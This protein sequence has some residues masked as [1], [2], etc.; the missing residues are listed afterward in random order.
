[1]GR[2]LWWEQTWKLHQ[3][4]KTQAR[5]ITHRGVRRW[6]LYGRQQEGNCQDWILQE[7]SPSS[8]HHFVDNVDTTDR[9]PSQSPTLPESSTRLILA[10]AWP[11]DFYHFL[12][13]DNAIGGIPSQ[14]PTLLEGPTQFTLATNRIN[15]LVRQWLQSLRACLHASVSM[16]I[17]CQSARQPPPHDFYTG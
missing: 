9:S 10:T 8:L 3:E 6:P 5:A 13:H 2:I 12:E 1:M 17:Y 16:C 15:C 14:S 11:G 7:A 4:D